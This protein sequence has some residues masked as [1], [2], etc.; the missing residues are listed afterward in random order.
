MDSY[1]GMN[2]VLGFL[3]GF[4]AIVVI[5]RIIFYIV[6]AIALYELAKN[7]G[8]SNIAFL[9]WIPVAQLYLLGVLAGKVKVFNSLDVSGKML[10]AILAISS[11]LANSKAMQRGAH[12][13]NPGVNTIFWIILTI[14]YFYAYSKIFLKLKGEKSTGLAIVSAIFPIIGSIY[15]IMNADKGFDQRY[16]LEEY[17][18]NYPNDRYE[19]DRYENDRYADSQ[20]NDRYGTSNSRNTVNL[21]KED[22]SKGQSANYNRDIVNNM[23]DNIH[24]S[25]EV[26]QTTVNDGQNTFRKSEMNETI[27]KD[28]DFTPVDDDS[29]KY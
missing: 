15:I 28:V 5:I 13:G 8:Y 18:G 14:A 24:P 3:F 7:N 26:T 9:A 19:N 27:V 20:T 22:L 10:G 16:D 21:N 23:D 29:K 12:D 25:V 6:T 1:A 4:I 11:I 2:A 17:D